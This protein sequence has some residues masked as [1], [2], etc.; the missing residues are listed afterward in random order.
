MIPKLLM[1]GAH[2]MRKRVL[3][4]LY[5]AFFCLFGLIIAQVSADTLT[6]CTELFQKGEFGAG[7]LQCEKII[8]SSEDMDDATCK[9]YVMSAIAYLL[10]DSQEQQT[11]I[12][13]LNTMLEGSKEDEEPDPSLNF[14]IAISSFLSGK[15]DSKALEAGLASAQNDW[16]AMGLIAKYLVSLKSGASDTELSE[17][18]DAYFASLAGFQ[19]DNW[20]TAW[21]PRLKQWNRWVI[22]GQGDKKSL[23]KLV[24]E[25]GKE[26]R[27]VRQEA[28]EDEKFAKIS[29]VLELYL[30]NEADKAK[31]LAAASSEEFASKKDEK[32]QPSIMA[33]EM[34][35]GKKSPSFQELFKLSN[36]DPQVWALASLS[37]FVK[38][39]S[40][41]SR[42]EPH[43]FLQCLDNYKK[44]CRAGSEKTEVLRWEPRIDVWEKWVE[45]G[46][47]A[48]KGL[49]ALL[50]SCSKKS[51]G[52]ASPA[53]SDSSQAPQA[54]SEGLPALADMTTEN[55]AAMR[56]G[57]YQ[58]RPRPAGLLFNDDEAK[59]YVMTL[60]EPARK[61]EAERYNKVCKI[62][63]Y[64]VQILERNSYPKGLK[65]KSGTASGTVSMANE[66]IVILKVGKKKTKRYEWTDLAFEQ[67]ED[68]LKYFA[69]QKATTVAGIVSK[70]EAKKNAAQDYLLLSLLCDWYARYDKSLEYARKAVSLD[71]SLEELVPPLLFK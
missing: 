34:L 26:S 61:P 28:G 47:K 35:A 23:E 51:A 5:L 14:S 1:E 11:R 63:G 70:D 44:N 24:A 45:G 3:N 48:Q 39:A 12:S 60:P 25:N 57:G 42:P 58:K 27:K 59:R 6:E 53:P 17:I 62:K 9:I 18:T 30:A 7:I 36:K 33:L 29:S 13:S 55:F 54:S 41:S 32:L 50:I 19:T 56:E 69:N 22:M 67:F 40:E 8:S 65:V 52:K 46:F 10:E 21:Y 68:F 43:L 37:F 31:K 20:A 66:N 64:L 2:K 71:P 4:P 38:Y 16:K 49:E 15:S